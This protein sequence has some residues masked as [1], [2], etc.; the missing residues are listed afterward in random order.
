MYVLVVKMDTIC[1]RQGEVWINTV[2]HTARNE[3]V[4]RNVMNAVFIKD[5]RKLLKYIVLI[6]QLLLYFIIMDQ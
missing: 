3:K 5:Q 2:Q 1:N 4:S 6:Q